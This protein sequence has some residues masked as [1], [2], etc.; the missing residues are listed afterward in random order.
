MAFSD[1]DWYKARLRTLQKRKERA[2]TQAEKE[3]IQKQIKDLQA[4]RKEKTGKGWGGMS[5]NS[6]WFK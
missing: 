5:W 6:R 4:E 1:D 3:A 2:K